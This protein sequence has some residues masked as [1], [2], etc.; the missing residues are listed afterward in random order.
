MS[1]IEAASSI[2]PPTIP[3]CPNCRTRFGSIWEVEEED[4][5]ETFRDERRRRGAPQ[6]Y[7]AIGDPQE[8]TRLLILNHV[9]DDEA[10][11]LSRV[12]NELSLTDDMIDIVGF[13]G[14][15]MNRDIFEMTDILRR[16]TEL[17]VTEPSLRYLWIMSRL[18]GVTHWYVAQIAAEESL[19]FFIPIVPGVRAFT[20]ERSLVLESFFPAAN[21]EFPPETIQM[22]L[23]TWFILEFLGPREMVSSGRYSMDLRRIREADEITH[24]LVCDSSRDHEGIL[25][26]DIL[27]WPRG[28]VFPGF[29]NLAYPGWP[30]TDAPSSHGGWDP[31]VDKAQCEA[32]VRVQKDF[33]AALMERNWTEAT[34]GDT[35]SVRPQEVETSQSHNANADGDENAAP[36]ADAH[37]ADE[38]EADEDDENDDEGEE[39]ISDTSSS[40]DGDDDSPD[41]LTELDPGEVTGSIGE[42]E[43]TDEETD[44]RHDTINDEVESADDE[45][46]SDSD[47]ET[48]SELDDE[49]EPYSPLVITDPDMFDSLTSMFRQP[50]TSRASSEEHSSIQ[51]VKEIINEIKTHNA[52]VVQSLRAAQEV[53]EGGSQDSAQ[54]RNEEGTNRLSP[55]P[56]HGAC[57]LPSEFDYGESLCYS[58]RIGFDTD[59]DM[60]MLDAL[61][62]LCSDVM[63]T[64]E[65]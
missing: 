7:Y 47:A 14:L 27:P 28:S 54:A 59:Q 29:Q 17:D 3:T 20:D 48:S 63:Y 43:R 4:R 11:L 52:E 32:I 18:F 55:E 42:G 58:N 1:W 16:R 10:E 13:E 62:A 23:S 60:E 35:E 2:V 30:T 34:R 6:H 44:G 24:W 37:E 46:G 65:G 51:H 61:D 25:E 12:R 26:I 33:F 36:G 45:S 21:A 22:P 9:E 50:S 41:V 39:D 38:H 19:G 15:E 53:L 40:D 31:D 8:I 64:S 57:V 56:A 49:E 5:A